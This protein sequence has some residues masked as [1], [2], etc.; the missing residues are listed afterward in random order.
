[1]WTSGLT[2]ACLSLD[3]TALGRSKK[4]SQFGLLSAFEP[5]RLDAGVCC[6][7]PVKAQV[8]VPLNNLNL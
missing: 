2:F 6:Q 7:Q 5:P 3:F 4:H 8:S 1:M